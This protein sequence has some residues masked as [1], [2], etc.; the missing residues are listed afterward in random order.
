MSFCTAQTASKPTVVAHLKGA[1]EADVQL[2]AIMENITDVNWD[3]VLG[4]LSSADLAGADM[5]IMVKADST[6]IYTERELSAIKDWLN[7]GGKAI[8]VAGDSDYGD[9]RLR[10]PTMNDV[11]EEI[12]SVLRIEECQVSDP[13]SSAG[14]DYRVLGL[15]E[16]CDSEVK[17]LVKGVTRALFHSPG[18]IL[19]YVGGE[20]VDLAKTRPENVYRIMWSSSTSII[21]NNN[22]PDP[23]LNEVGEEGTFVLMA[24]E[25]DYAKKN[26]IIAAGEAPY[27]QYAG[28]YM[29]EL[30][31]YDRYTEEYPQQGE[32]LF[33]N[34][35]KWTLYY[36]STI[37]DQQNEIMTLESDVSSLT[38]EVS[39][40]RADVS[41][42]NGKVTGLEGEVSDLEG[43][44][45]GL[46]GQVAGLQGDVSTWQMYAAVALVL[47]LIIGAAVV[48]VMKR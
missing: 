19:A 37:I 41:S 32:T 16:K 21:T 12:G 2:K 47:G 43:Q 18:D 40:L 13:I 45:S 1:L 3:L 10:Q 44:V 38:G 31:R 5:L 9:D 34:I 24:M 6:L 27:D 20:Y 23:Q 33:K 29:P 22:E 11:L 28:M 15:S 7:E 14:A 36:A 26:I 42:L 48:Y 30:R 35:V 17:Y 8:W 4:E 25:I 46:E 39:G